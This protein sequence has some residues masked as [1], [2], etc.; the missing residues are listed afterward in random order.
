[1]LSICLDSLAQERMIKEERK[2]G[3]PVAALIHRLDLPH[4]KVTVLLT[5]SLD[6]MTE[7]EK[8]TPVIS[9]SHS[10][11]IALAQLQIFMHL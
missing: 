6:D 2:A 7:E 4:G 5:N 8:T 10:I 3:N 9:V 11:F 1:M